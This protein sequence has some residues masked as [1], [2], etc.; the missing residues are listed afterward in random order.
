MARIETR[1]ALAA[2]PLLL[3]I[4]LLFAAGCATLAPCPLPSAPAPG[5]PADELD[6]VLFLIGDAGEA[7][8][9]G[10]PV[11]GALRTAVGEAVATLG[12]ERVTVVFLGDNL[13]PDGMVAPAHPERKTLQRRLDAQLGVLAQPGA[14]LGVFIPGNHDWGENARDGGERLARQEAYLD[15]KGGGRVRFEPRGGCPGPVVI[16]R[17]GQLRLIVLDTQWWLRRGPVPH[18]E[19]GGCPAASRQELLRQ[20]EGA[21]ATAGGRRVVIAAHHPL[22]SGGPHG[23]H[24][25]PRSLGWRPQDLSHVGYRG[26]KAELEAVFRRQPPLLYAAGHDHGLQVLRGGG[27]PFQL[28]SGAGTSTRLSGVE[29]LPATLACRQ[30]TGFARLELARSG[31]ARL[32]LFYPDP[33]GLPAELWSAPIAAPASL[34]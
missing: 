24:R 12:G 18:G 28:I 3:A 11:L 17:G 15:E 32:A 23:G 5:L 21:I 22:E 7:N 16:D 30:G 20:L 2:G 13:Y 4:V 1:P 26:L 8:P 6:S 25:F 14:P 31:G 10:E 9:L 34:P 27:Y 29:A 19:R 33:D